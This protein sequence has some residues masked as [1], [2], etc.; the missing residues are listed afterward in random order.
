MTTNV[1]FKSGL[2][3]MCERVNKLSSLSFLYFESLCASKASEL[4]TECLRNEWSFEQTSGNGLRISVP[5][6]Q[7]ERFEASFF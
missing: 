5:N 4:M 7:I 6:E 2:K 3:L 1:I